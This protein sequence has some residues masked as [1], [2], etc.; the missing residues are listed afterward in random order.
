MVHLL[1]DR[2]FESNK[3]ERRSREREREKK[4]VFRPAKSDFDASMFYHHGIIMCFRK[5]LAFYSIAKYFSSFTSSHSLSNSSTAESFYLSLCAYA[6]VGNGNDEKLCQWYEKLKR[7]KTPKERERYSK[8][9][10]SSENRRWITMNKFQHHSPRK[11]CILSGEIAIRHAF[12]VHSLNFVFL[13]PLSFC[14]SV[15]LIQQ[16]MADLR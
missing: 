9:C 4:A 1:F 7:I 5:N 2:N 16:Q 12:N 3:S 13:S 8:K 6:S 10:D 15:L 11:Y 14:C